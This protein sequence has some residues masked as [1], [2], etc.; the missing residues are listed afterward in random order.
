MRRT[1]RYKIFGKGRL[2]LPAITI[3]MVAVTLT[4]MHTVSTFRT[5][6]R[7]RRQWEKFLEYNARDIISAV[8]AEIGLEDAFSSNRTKELLDKLVEN[9]HLAY[10][11]ITDQGN[12]WIVSGRWTQPP[13]ISKGERD[14]SIRGQAESFHSQMRTLPDGRIVFEVW[15]LLNT[16]GVRAAVVG[17]WMTPLQEARKQDIRHAVLMGTILLILGSAAFFFIFVVQNYYLID[18]TLAEMKSYTENVV[19]SM[20]SGLITVDTEGRIVSTN[21]KAA[22]LLGL[23]LRQIHGEPLETVIPPHYVNIYELLKHGE[24]ILEREIDCPSPRGNVPLS[25]SVTPLLDP[26][27]VNIGAV[28][29]LRDLQEIRDL[30]ERVR[31]SERLASLG[32]LASGIAHEIRNPLSSI[33]GF[34]QYFRDKFETGSE[35]R[36]YADIM[37]QEVERLNRVITQLLDFARP[38]E[39]HLGMHPLSRILDHPIKLMESQLDKKG[40]KVVRP[41]SSADT[42][43]LRVDPDQMTQALLNIFL[44]AME[45]M[46]N[47][48]E[49]RVAAVLRPEV[50]KVEI[51]ISDTGTGVSRENLPRI[52]DPFFSTKKK[53]TGLGLAITAKIIEAHRGEIS[54]ESEEG[55]G[56]IFK[57]LLPF[58]E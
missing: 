44:N 42:I 17:L 34:A 48:G 6:D 2:Y 33:K 29:I 52:F 26:E 5:L 54:A 8:K 32:R 40:I 43:K 39:L 30:Q 28:I 4:V 12:R 3:V 9:P 7:N 38:K 23:N 41:P 45:S 49:L 37:I 22:Q 57:V 47:G 50:N 21:Q 11:G 14:S 25:L 1:Q 10:V 13:P 15:E 53:G 27:G 56:T 58:A 20:A 19:E 46:E 35:D 51:R 16:P 36:S 55:R 24:C 31:R 18:R